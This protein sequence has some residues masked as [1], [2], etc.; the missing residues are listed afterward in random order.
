MA[1]VRAILLQCV[2]SF[3]FSSGSFTAFTGDGAEEAEGEFEAVPSTGIVASVISKG[4]SSTKLRWTGPEIRNYEGM[5]V[6]SYIAVKIR[7]HG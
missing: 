5:G 4:I 6:K 2:G 1:Q 3:T 7:C